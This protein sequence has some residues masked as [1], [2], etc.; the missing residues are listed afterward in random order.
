MRVL[1]GILGGALV[2]LMVLEIFL[3]YLVPQRVRRGP[4][5]VRI[6]FE[7]AWRPWRWL[8]H[9][10]P[11]R[12]ADT[13]LGLYGPF[14]LIMNLALWVLGMMLGYAA[15]QWAGGSQLAAGHSVGFG[16]D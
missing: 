13:M 7:I 3:T 4:R 6:F 1:V 8:A 14:G 11:A 9:R 10:L 15:L 2:A 5:V 16:R 12:G